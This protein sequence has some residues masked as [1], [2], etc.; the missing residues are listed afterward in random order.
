MG[1]PPR[2]GSSNPSESS[3]GMSSADQS[4]DPASNRCHLDDGE[5]AVSEDGAQPVDLCETLLLSHG[6]ESLLGGLL[7][8]IHGSIFLVVFFDGE[9][10]A[11]G[12]QTCPAEQ[13]SNRGDD[14][15]GAHCCSSFV[16]ESNQSET[17]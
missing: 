11:D 16:P 15:R 2:L 14:I 10:A 13:E 6:R 1:F 5:A 8:G 9:P 17:S 4:S 12:D 3:A 7:L